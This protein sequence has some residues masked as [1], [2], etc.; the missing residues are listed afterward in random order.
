MTAPKHHDWFDSDAGRYVLER[1]L[2]WFDATSA[3]LFG[4][5]AMQI[6]LCQ[7][8][9]LRANRIPFRYCGK[10]AGGH[11]RLLPEMLPLAS[12]SLDLVALPHALEF[13]PN[14]HQLLREVER[15][16]RPEGRL[17]LSGFNP[18]SFFGTRRWLGPR[19]AY[20]WNGRFLRLTRIKDWLS[21]L[22]LELAGGR[23]ACYAPPIDRA[24]LLRAF[25]F[26]ESAGDR[27]WA[28]GGGVY[29]L[30]AVKRVQGMR[31][32]TP[33]WSDAW[34]AKPELAG[35]ANR[36]GTHSRRDP[37]EPEAGAD[38]MRR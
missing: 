16:L 1:E 9:C 38:I 35:S 34:L 8:D 29:M 5:M 24:R 33:Q 15:V 6:G 23:M 3:D 36:L 2:A 32:I 27:W 7:I 14:P 22:G 25:G 11:V 37:G 20:P 13:S 4:Y 28:L 26:L 17:L 18:L 30:H 19:H 12:Q 21:L 10:P 31:L